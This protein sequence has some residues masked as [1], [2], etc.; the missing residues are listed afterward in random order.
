M[1]GARLSQTIFVLQL[2][3]VLGGCDAEKNPPV[4]VLFAASGLLDEGETGQPKFTRTEIVPLKEG[5]RY[6]WYMFVR[7]NKPTLRYEEEIAM[8]GPTTWGNTSGSLVVTEDKRGAKV[9]REVDPKGGWLRG[10]W[11]INSD[12]PQGPVRIKIT[13]EGSVVQN[14]SWTLSPP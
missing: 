4:E 5:Q 3:L 7:T 1:V 13:I 2:F 11:S 9:V 10:I 6:G 8:A 14:F 12:D